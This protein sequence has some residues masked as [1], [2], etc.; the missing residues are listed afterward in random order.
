MTRFTQVLIAIVAVVAIVAATLLI[1][2]GMNNDRVLRQACQD[3]NG[4][5]TGTAC[6]YSGAIE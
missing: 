4:V 1:I 2:T 5:W 6:A 3:Y